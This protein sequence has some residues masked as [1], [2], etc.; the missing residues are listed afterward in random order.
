MS[1]STKNAIFS[2]IN[3]RRYPSK[4]K[5]STIV[6]VF[7]CDDKTEPDPKYLDCQTSIVY[8]KALRAETC[9]AIARE[10]N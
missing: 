7:K 2:M 5:M 10:I 3:L 9:A 1:F 6:P 8:L 4:L